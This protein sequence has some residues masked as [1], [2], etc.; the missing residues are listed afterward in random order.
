[1]VLNKIWVRNLGTISQTFPD[2]NH[3]A[4]L[5]NLIFL[6]FCII[7]DASRN[8]CDLPT[9]F[10][11]FQVEK[12][13]V[14]IQGLFFHLAL[15]Y[16]FVSQCHTVRTSHINKKSDQ[17]EIIP[18]V[19]LNNIFL[20]DY[21]AKQAIWTFIIFFFSAKNIFWMIFLEFD[22]LSQK[23]VLQLW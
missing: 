19:F 5:E 3:R 7:L 23:I 1:M 10:Q 4:S 2:L 15:S 8:F 16:D 17:G 9:A 21:F 22:Q 12:L 6:I 11:E 14:W 13:A 20:I 18:L